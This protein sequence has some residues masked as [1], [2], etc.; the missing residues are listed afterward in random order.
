MMWGGG[1]G[2]VGGL[3]MLLFWGVL[4]A[5]IVLAVRWLSDSRS[6]A[7][8]S[9]GRRDPLEILRERYARGEIDDEE[10]ERRKRLLES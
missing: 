10:F 7:G 5:L 3:M 1:Y 2:F 6:G 9:A 4:I 8:G